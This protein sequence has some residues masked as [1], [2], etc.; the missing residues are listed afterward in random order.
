M[1]I[2]DTKK[3]SKKQKHQNIRIVQNKTFVDITKIWFMFIK[4]DTIF[5]WNFAFV[6]ANQM[7]I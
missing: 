1:K 4:L 6:L 2:L 7:F 3:K 5:V